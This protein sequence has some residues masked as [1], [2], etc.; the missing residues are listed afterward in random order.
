M[1][2]QV[3]HWVCGIA[4]SIGLAGCGSAVDQSADLTARN[5]AA[6]VQRADWS[7]VEAT[8]PLWVADSPHRRAMLEQIRQVMPR[9]PPNEVQMLYWTYAAKAGTRKRVERLTI[10]YLYS[11]RTGDVVL[12]AVLDKSNGRYEVS[13][14]QARPV[15]A[16][17]V[18]ANALDAPGKTWIHLGFMSG[19]ALSLGLMILAAWRAWQAKA[20]KWRWAW[21]A[22]ALLGLGSLQMNWT[23]GATSSWLA[24]NLLGVTVTKS[25]SPLAPWV[26]R[27]TLPIGALLVLWR[28]SYYRPPK[29]PPPL[30]FG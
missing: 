25:V 6:A 16:R 28:M 27:F 4:M 23:T 13:G 8:S 14:F 7:T 21:I 15:D 2:R 1:R 24:V 30:S 10:D 19:M 3:W 9:D 18:A 17:S 26:F 12:R 20:L 11:F 22:L 5:F 29:R